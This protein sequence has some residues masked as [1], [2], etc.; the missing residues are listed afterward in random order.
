MLVAQAETLVTALLQAE[1]L[2]AAP[3]QEEEVGATLETVTAE[4]QEEAEEASTEP[5]I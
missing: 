2:G 3:L 5:Q 1:Q 4:E